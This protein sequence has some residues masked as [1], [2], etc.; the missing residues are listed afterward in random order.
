MCVKVGPCSDPQNRKRSG[1]QEEIWVCRGFP[2]CTVSSLHQPQSVNGSQESQCQSRRQKKG[3]TRYFI[4][5]HEINLSSI[6]IKVQAMIVVPR[7]SIRLF[8]HSHPRSSPLLSAPLLSSAP[9]RSP[10]LPSAPLAPPSPQ[11]FID[12]DLSDRIVGVSLC[13]PKA[14]SG[15]AVLTQTYGH[16]S[17]RGE[18]RDMH[19]P[20]YESNRSERTCVT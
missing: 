7:F 13:H 12:F 20:G 9:L 3:N 14:R 17:R 16:R 1:H 8:P 4:I 18:L 6:M 10:P 19:I 11:H 2:N 15:S 5:I